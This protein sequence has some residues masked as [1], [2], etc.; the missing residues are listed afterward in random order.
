MKDE[1]TD[2]PEGKGRPRCLFNNRKGASAVE[3]AIILPILVAMVFG[4]IDF[5][6]LFHAKMITTHL[7]RE[8]AS[9]ASRD[10]Q[11]GAGLLTM[12]QAGGSPLDLAAK[13]RIYVWRIEAGASANQPNP[14][15]NAAKSANLGSLGAASSIGTGKPYLGLNEDVYA[16]LVFNGDNQTADIAEITV[17]E[18]FY[19]YTPV[20]PVVMNAQVLSSRAVF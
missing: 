6:R 8:G 11:G 17:V 14:T 7:A 19:E 5:G 12:L 18:V 4:I 2:S 20:T 3:F 1:T 9:L 10:I 15:I 13:G 16:H